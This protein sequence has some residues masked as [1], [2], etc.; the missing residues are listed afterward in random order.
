MA[1][2]KYTG[3]GDIERVALTLGIVH[4]VAALTQTTIGFLVALAHLSGKDEWLVALAIAD[5]CRETDEEYTPEE[6]EEVRQ[7]LR[8]AE[9]RVRKQCESAGIAPKTNIS[10][11]FEGISDA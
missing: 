9:E 2:E 6:R 10:E 5:A 4:G 7:G 3:T 8:E 11:W 1:K